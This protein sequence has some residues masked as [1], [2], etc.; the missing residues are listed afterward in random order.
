ML[1]LLR[2]ASERDW[3]ATMCWFVALGT[4]SAGAAALEDHR[5]AGGILQLR[6][7][8]NPH[9]AR[10]FNADEVLFEVTQGG[11]SC[12]IYT[13]PKAIVPPE[14]EILRGRYR[15]KGWSE[16]KITRALDAAAS[17]K[18]PSIGRNAEMGPERAFRD[19][20]TEQVRDFGGVRLFAHMYC[21]SQDEE[22]VTCK[23]RRRIGLSE[24]LKSGFP[25]DELIQIVEDAE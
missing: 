25:P 11:C 10:I 9:I 12:G 22:E 4:T 7:S 1:N 5:R 17:A 19:A 6:R 14:N 24:F 16:S 21:G 15:R 8:N 18:S 23:S 2:I 13:R 3:C 20:V